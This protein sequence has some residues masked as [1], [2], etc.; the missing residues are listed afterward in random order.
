QHNANLIKQRFL[1]RTPIRL[2][3]QDIR[4]FP[5][6]GGNLVLFLYNPFDEQ[7]V[8]KV[9]EAV[10]TAL[11]IAQ[12]TVYV[13]YYNP[14]AGHCFDASPLLRRYLAAT[15]PYATGELGYGPDTEDPIVVWQGGTRV[16]LND[17]LANA[18]I[19]ITEPRYRVR[20]VP[21]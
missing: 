11:T 10:N 17:S 1:R 20:L 3:V 8:A 19:Q 13:V 12:R 4:Q 16:G 5:L 2:V 14:V 7:V 21:A 15:L 6:P 9:V 18:R